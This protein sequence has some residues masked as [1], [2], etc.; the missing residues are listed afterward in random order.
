[1][2]DMV[3]SVS[4]AAEGND[5]AEPEQGSAASEVEAPLHLQRS[6]AAAGGT[7]SRSAAQQQ[8]VQAARCTAL[9][10]DPGAALHR[11]EIAQ[12]CRRFS[13]LLDS[14][15]VELRRVRQELEAGSRVADA[16]EKVGRA[17]LEAALSTA[18]AAAEAASA[19]ARGSMPAV[20]PACG[21][22]PAA[23]EIVKLSCLALPAPPPAADKADP[24]A[25][26][27]AALGTE[28]LPDSIDICRHASAEAAAAA[29]QFPILACLPAATHIAAHGSA[30]AEIQAAVVAADASTS[31][32][33]AETTHADGWKL[34]AEATTVGLPVLPQLPG[35]CEGE[36]WQ[37]LV[38]SAQGLEAAPAAAAADA[39]VGMTDEGQRMQRECCAAVTSQQGWLQDELQAARPEAAFSVAS[40]EPLPDSPTSARSHSQASNSSSYLSSVAAAMSGRDDGESG[41]DGELREQSVT[42]EDDA[43]PATEPATAGQQDAQ[44]QEDRQELLV[45]LAAL[46]ILPAPVAEKSDAGPAPEGEQSA[47]PATDTSIACM[48]AGAGAAVQPSSGANENKQERGGSPAEP[49]AA[50]LADSPGWQAG[51]PYASGAAEEPATSEGQPVAAQA[52]PL[53]AQPAP[54]EEA[55]ASNPQYQL[56]RPR[57]PYHPLLADEQRAAAARQAELAA[58]WRQLRERADMLA[59][60]HEYAAEL[61]MDATGDATGCSVPAGSHLTGSGR[62]AKPPGQ[63]LVQA[64]ELEQLLADAASLGLAVPVP[65]AWRRNG[66]LWQAGQQPPPAGDGDMTPLA[67]SLGTPFAGP[68]SSGSDNGTPASSSCLTVSSG[69]TSIGVA[70]RW[71]DGCKTLVCV[72]NCFVALMML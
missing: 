25:L 20:R 66:R 23:E 17:A 44:Q 60:W 42:T 33:M 37:Q 18:E 41:L 34:A 21:A 58:G 5:S 72:Y 39:V 45:K 13:Q 30:C 31:H 26:A 2:D 11:S 4:R 64:A 51:E 55:L 6:P 8:A 9:S 1:M 35:S 49:S 71:E 61:G 7:A 14:N 59:L 63:L 24:P 52:S 69:S 68:E 3:A 54:A 62:A 32:A 46:A 15:D 36:P 57:A 53:L 50:W 56:A 19:R 22:Q 43:Q 16:V 29:P 48:L 40:N 27:P 28:P 47:E 38:P 67:T 70:A 10:A 12:L 65:A